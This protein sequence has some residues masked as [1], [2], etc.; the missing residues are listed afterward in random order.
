MKKTTLPENAELGGISDLLRKQ[1]I[2]YVTSFADIMNRFGETHFMDP[3]RFTALSF[4]T[5][6]GG[7]LT[8]TELAKLMFRSKHSIT[9]IIDGLE[10]LNYVTR[11]QDKKDRRSIHVK[12]TSEGVAHFQKHLLLGNKHMKE[13]MSCM[14]DDE[15]DQLIELIKRLRKRLIEK[16]RKE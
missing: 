10:N 11:I 2:L 1:K 14:S 16:M 15:W 6:R 4:L 8:P 5:T 13:I 9:K 3:L 7:S 12:I